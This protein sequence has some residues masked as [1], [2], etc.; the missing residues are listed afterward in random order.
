MIL[1]FLIF[2]ILALQDAKCC[3]MEFT[4]NERAR[5]E[6]R[7]DVKMPV[8]IRDVKIGNTFPSGSAP[9]LPMEFGPDFTIFVVVVILKSSRMSHVVKGASG[10]LRR[11][12]ST[13]YDWP[14]GELYQTKLNNNFNQN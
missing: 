10:G 6:I 7:G 14:P 9:P 2:W 5:R 11:G 13:T 12:R 8:K 3:K 1:T 4:R